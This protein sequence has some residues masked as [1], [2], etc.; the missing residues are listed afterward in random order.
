MA[1]NAKN[2]RYDAGRD[3]RKH[4]HLVELLAARPQEGVLFP[5]VGTRRAGKTWALRGLEKALN[6]GNEK[7]ARYVDLTRTGGQL[8]E[9]FS[10]DCLLIDEPELA[11]QGG[12]VR[13]PSEFLKWC[14]RMHD[15][16]K[17]L[18]VAMTPA[19]WVALQREGEP[20]K[21][22]SPRELQ[23]LLPLTESQAEELAR[24]DQAK[25]LLP[26]LD[27]SWKRN[28]FLLEL[29]FQVAEELGDKAASDLW[30]LQRQAR[31]R[32]DDT[33]FFYFQTVYWNG[34]TDEQ[35]KTLNSVS[36]SAEVQWSELDLLERCGLISHKGTNP[37]LADPVLEAKLCPLRIH[38]IS[39]LHF[40]P[41]SAERVDMK[42][43]G[44]HAEHFR[45]GLGPKYIRDDYLNFMGGLKS[46]G[47]APHL[48]II[49]GDIA[50]WADDPQYEEAK[51]WLGELQKRLAEHPCL[52][53]NE[54]HVLIVGGNHDVD[55][56]QTEGAAGAGAR[57]RHVPFARAFEGIPR[58]KRVKL[59]E[60]PATR[61]L[62]VVRYEDLDV[63]V[64]LLGSAEFGGEA[65]QDPVKMRL[66]EMVEQLWKTALA[67]PDDEKSKALREQVSKLDPGLVNDKDLKKI[68]EEPWSRSI[69]I[70]VLHHPVT[71]LPATEVGR[72]VGLI[73]AGEVKD[74]LLEKR[75][76]LVLHGHSHTGWFSKEQW[77]GR[78]ESRAL[79]IA[80]A[81]SLGSKEIQEHNG[82]NEI[83]ISW[84]Q[85]G[86]ETTWSGTVE[87]YVREGGTW[88][89]EARMPFGNGA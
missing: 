3:V 45:S 62:A 82:F 39:D 63:E 4:T 56:R 87:R 32:S 23:F 67:R 25:R 2:P 16:G 66:Q 47:K 52:K 33:E 6:Q 9:T 57:K 41:K 70:A 31:D 12:R 29:L 40:G 49:S 24:T 26:Q 30:E 53:P 36:R 71:P 28:P 59:E 72:F 7:R 17:T 83:S 78:H 77:P 64:L 1:F 44:A 51:A 18:L 15:G 46:S 88:R 22:V 81:P 11:G 50:E 61:P 37:V 58:S 35:R 14:L 5:L 48:L 73:N 21:Q 19:E 20:S 27:A 68:S 55:W 84:I 13:S 74:R 86:Q 69:R 79:W 54:P 10:E 89:P 75:F 60:P 76:C 38:H 43:K 85:K 8:P 80:S 65:E 34:L 42:E